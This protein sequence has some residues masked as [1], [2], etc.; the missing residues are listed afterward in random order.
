MVITAILDNCGDA[1]CGVN[2]DQDNRQTRVAISS[3]TVVGCFQKWINFTQSNVLFS[4]A[5]II[6]YVDAFHY[7][8]IFIPSSYM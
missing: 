6:L 3:Y 8:I 5:Q 2:S 7:V 4:V 1:V